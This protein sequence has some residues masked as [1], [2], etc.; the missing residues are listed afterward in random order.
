M[1]SGNWDGKFHICSSWPSTFLLLIPLCVAHFAFFGHVQEAERETG[2]GE[3]RVVKVKYKHKQLV[4]PT[5][6]LFLKALSCFSKDL[7]LMPSA[8]IVIHLQHLKWSAGYRC[9]TSCG[10]IHAAYSQPNQHFTW[11]ERVC[12]MDLCVQKPLEC[13]YVPSLSGF[14]DEMN[15]FV[16]VQLQIIQ[17]K[18]SRSAT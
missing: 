4:V 16:Q 10:C 17:I 5:C 18:I 7:L 8:V 1:R 15:S 6:S 13:W 14:R 2:S 12:W 11:Q 3:S 9:Y